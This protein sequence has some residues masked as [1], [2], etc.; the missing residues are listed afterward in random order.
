MDKGVKQIRDGIKKRK[1]QRLKL[2]RND[3]KESP[4]MMMSEE[5]KHGFDMPFYNPTSKIPTYKQNKRKSGNVLRQV[6]L[7]VALFLFCALMF[8]T[9]LIPFQGAQLW[10]EDALTEEFPFA[11][12]HHWYEETLGVPLT[13]TPKVPNV[14]SDTN[15][16]SSMPIHGEVV[17]TFA[18]NGKGVMISPDEETNVH[19]WKQG[20]VIFAGNDKSTDKTVLIQHSDGSKS[21]YGMLSTIDVHLYELVGI[22]DR[23]GTFNPS[24]N[25]SVAYFSIEKDKQFIDPS[26][27]MRVD[28]V[29]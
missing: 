10:A 11:K 14:P 23:I 9:N 8:K 27:I 7:S 1:Q 28:D 29:R 17:E 25:Q 15:T 22:N 18:N 4:S 16:L 12:V 3:P 5:E 24:E 19:S 2:E 13:L 26:E 6:T 21:T 20:V